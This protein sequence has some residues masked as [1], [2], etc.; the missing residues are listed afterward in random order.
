MNLVS[1]EEIR[2]MQMLN[3]LKQSEFKIFTLC[4]SLLLTI[5]ILAVIFCVVTHTTFS[6][7]ITNIVSKEIQF[8][9]KLSL[10]TSV[11]S[12]FLCIVVSIPVSYALARY[13]FAGKILSIPFWI[14]HWH[15]LP[16]WLEWDFY[17]CL[18]QQHSGKYWHE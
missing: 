1:I 2:S 10:I 18:A 11:I 14:S 13:K 9:I 3:K 12:T 15:Y 4:F 17:F 5:F 8:A 7:L 6:A 16:W